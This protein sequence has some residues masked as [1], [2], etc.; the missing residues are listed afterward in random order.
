MCRCPGTRDVTR[1]A[2]APR[3]STRRAPASG[4][5]ATP[6]GSAT[7]PTSA[8]RSRSSP[9]RAAPRQPVTTPATRAPS[10]W[11]AQNNTNNFTANTFDPA[12]GTGGVSGTQPSTGGSVDW[13]TVQ[14]A[15]VLNGRIWFGQGGKF[16]YTTWD[17]ANGFG[18]PQN[19][20]P[21]NDPYWDPVVNGS[22]PSGTT[23]T[24]KA[25]DFYSELPSVTGMFYA[26]RTIYYTLSGHKGLFSRAFSPDTA[27][28]SVANQVTGGI[29]SPVKNTVVPDS[30]GV[31]DFS[32]AGG[33]FVANGSLWY[34]TKA[35]G[36]LHK[37]PWSGTGVT[38]ASSVDASATGNWAGKAVFV[39]P[40]A[41]PVAPVAS[42]TVS[43]PAATCFFDASA[44]TAPGSTI[45]SYAWDFG[46][47]TT[48]TG[49]KPQ[50]TYTA[51]GDYQVTL[52]VTSAQNLTNSVTHTASVTTLTSTGINFV[53][54]ANA[55][56]GGD[57][58]SVTVPSR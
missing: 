43:C 37:A 46:D 53:A 19:V 48:G 12:T 8:A 32:N 23:Y 18:T 57:P 31:V 3:S 24:G 52:T 17:G 5:A 25:T 34:A 33:M 11:P 44:S 45:T 56:G 16:F 15:F 27:A 22:P 6:T 30:G 42:Y 58:T 36:K 40:V 47:G 9:S 51:V 7:S 41:P 14:G 50:H 2:T 26:N 49:V 35:D 21:Y 10:S 4:S 38:G 39:S 20:D 54:Q 13:S 28:S 1:A 29:I 55:A